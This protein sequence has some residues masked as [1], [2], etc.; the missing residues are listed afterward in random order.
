[1]DHGILSWLKCS[2]S[3]VAG[4]TIV[5]ILVGGEKMYHNFITKMDF[6]R[7]FK[8]VFDQT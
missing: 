2:N 8:N 5:Q 6:T 3:L 1:M 4:P 7:E